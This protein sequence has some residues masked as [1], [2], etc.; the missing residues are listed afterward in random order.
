MATSDSGADPRAARR[1][2][3]RRAT[4]ELL[5]GVVALDALFMAIYFFGG[6][7]HG[8]PKTRMY[9]TVVWT[10]ATALVVATLL[11]RVRKLRFTR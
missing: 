7:Q 9:F 4:L 2:A 3:L 1:A 5:L 10:V 6:I 11:K 8:A